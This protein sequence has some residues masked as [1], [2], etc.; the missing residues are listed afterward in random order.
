MPFTALLDL[1]V[2][3]PLP[4]PHVAAAAASWVLT[5]EPPWALGKFLELHLAGIYLQF[6]LF[7]SSN[8]VCPFLC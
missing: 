1:R 3:S 4:S 2:S 6:S 8:Y 7:D 5:T